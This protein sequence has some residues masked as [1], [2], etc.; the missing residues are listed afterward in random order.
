[1]KEKLTPELLPMHNV[2]NTKDGRIVIWNIL[3][4]CGAAPGGGM[5]KRKDLTAHE[6]G[7]DLIDEII[8]NHFDEFSIMIKELKQG[9]YDGGRDKSNE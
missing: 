5:G 7:V 8:Y 2:L 3:E 6:L 1:M 9:V 4:R